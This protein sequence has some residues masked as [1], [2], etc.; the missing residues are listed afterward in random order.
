MHFNTPVSPFPRVE[1]SLRH[2]RLTCAQNSDFWAVVTYKAAY[3]MVRSEMW[4][5]PSSRGEAQKRDWV[6]GSGQSSCPGYMGQAV[7]GEEGGRHL[8]GL[9][10]CGVERTLV[11]TVGTGSQPSSYSISQ[12]CVCW[13]P[14]WPLLAFK[15]FSLKEII[16]ENLIMRTFDA[17]YI[18]WLICC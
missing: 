18:L 17:A 14:L 4:G 1:I 8:F 6:F 12:A 9:E 3:V 13:T 5:C 11:L 15:V 2:Y 7:L 16:S 10:A